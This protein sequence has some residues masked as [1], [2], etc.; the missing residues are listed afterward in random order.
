MMTEKR[1]WKNEQAFT[2]IYMVKEQNR[3]SASQNW[4]EGTVCDV[5]NKAVG[6]L[7][8]PVC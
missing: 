4:F 6:R 2:T 3:T 5:V 7:A 8:D 1:H